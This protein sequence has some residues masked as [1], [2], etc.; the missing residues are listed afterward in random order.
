MVEGTTAAEEDSGALSLTFQHAPRVGLGDDSCGRTTSGGERQKCLI[1]NF[2]CAKSRGDDSGGG[3]QRRLIVNFSECTKSRWRGR[4][5][6][7][8]QQWMT[9]VWKTAAPYLIFQ[10][11]AERTQHR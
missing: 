10:E 8:R 11:C 2:K 5:N 4:Q 9:A 6:R 1:F 3:R 7:G